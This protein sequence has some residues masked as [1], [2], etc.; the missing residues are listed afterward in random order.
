MTTSEPEGPRNLR[1]HTTLHRSSVAL[2]AG[3]SGA[4]VLV[5]QERVKLGRRVADLC[6]RVERGDDAEPVSLKQ[7]SLAVDR[8]DNSRRPEQPPR[9]ATL[10]RQR[11]R[12]AADFALDCR[13]V[14]TVLSPYTRFVR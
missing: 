4:T 3:L 7:R 6:T 12:L 10:D 14:L 1:S 2:L 5:G 8:P 9:P 11:D 13:D